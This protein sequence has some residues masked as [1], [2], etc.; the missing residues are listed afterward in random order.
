MS[1][2]N[3]YDFNSLDTYYCWKYKNNCN[4]WLII[5]YSL[6]FSINTLWN[7]CVNCYELTSISSQKLHKTPLIRTVR[8][9]FFEN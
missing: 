7:S 2:V 8:M 5:P 3:Y 4:K 9:N 1:H 6:V